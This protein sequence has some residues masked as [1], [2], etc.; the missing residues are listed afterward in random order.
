MPSIKAAAE[1][2]IE[3]E[4]PISRKLL[5]KKVISRWGITRSGNKVEEIF[6]KSLAGI[7]KTITTDEDRV[8]IWKAGQSPD[9]YNIYRR[10]DNSEMKRSA[11]DIP[12][13]EILCAAREVLAEQGGMSENALIRETAKKFGFTR[14]GSVIESTFGYAV[15]KAVQDGKLSAAEN[16][17]IT[18]S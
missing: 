1:E 17:N 15:R 12:S 14:T 18:L 5:I 2:I 7:T 8:F 4:S 16:G 11:D 13:Q 10:D 3:T 6:N 9:E